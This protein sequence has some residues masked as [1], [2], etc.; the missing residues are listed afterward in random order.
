MEESIRPCLRCDAIV[1][2]L[3]NYCST[4]GAYLGKVAFVLPRPAAAAQSGEYEG[5]D[6]ILQFFYVACGLLAVGA[7][8]AAFVGAY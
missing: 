4:C 6:A 7:A 3:D 2:E 1:P 8:S 5:L